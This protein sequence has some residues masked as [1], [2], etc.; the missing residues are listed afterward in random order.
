MGISD[1]FGKIS[2]VSLQRKEA[3]HLSWFLNLPTDNNYKQILS[4]YLLFCLR[5]LP[6]LRGEA[7]GSCWRD[8][9]PKLLTR[10]SLRRLPSRFVC[11]STST[12]TIKLLDICRTVEYLECITSMARKLSL[13]VTR[14]NIPRW[15]RQASTTISLLLLSYGSRSC[16]A[17]TKYSQYDHIR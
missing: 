9:Q 15:Q 11:S 4:L 10:G 13:L 7:K 1:N 12:S 3:T 5:Y 6:S 2:F 14:I 8:G 17:A 16:K